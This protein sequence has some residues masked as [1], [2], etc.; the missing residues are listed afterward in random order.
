[1]AALQDE[2]APLDADEVRRHDGEAGVLA[3]DA[4]VD[5]FEAPLVH[6]DQRGLVADRLGPYGQGEWPELRVGGRLE[7]EDELRHAADAERAGGVL[8]AAGEVK[9]DASGRPPRLQPGRDQQAQV[10]LGGQLDPLAV[11]ESVGVRLDL[12]RGIDVRA[13]RGHEAALERAFE[14][15]GRLGREPGDVAAE[16][17]VRG[18]LGGEPGRGVGRDER[19]RRQLVESGRQIAGPRRGQADVPLVV[20]E[21]VVPRLEVM[22]GELDGVGC[23]QVFYPA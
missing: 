5:Q 3:A 13:G 2:V 19:G 12:R 14:P 10:D 6:V 23:E 4:G 16:G 17:R 1:M 8:A 20:E 21:T 18:R 7:V 11:V 9:H 15:R 22:P